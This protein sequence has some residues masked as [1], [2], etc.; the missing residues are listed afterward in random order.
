[1]RENHVLIYY[2]M[3]TSVLGGVALVAL[4]T[5]FDQPIIVMCVQGATFTVVG[6]AL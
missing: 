5:I 4:S 3:D 1:M 2:L 6:L